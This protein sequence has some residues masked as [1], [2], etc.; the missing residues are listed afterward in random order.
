[1]LNDEP[2]RRRFERHSRLIDLGYGSTFE[3]QH[4]QRVAGY[5][6]RIWRMHDCP[7]LGT[8]GDSDQVFGLQ[9]AERLADG[10]SGY[11]ELLHQPTF[12]LQGIPLFELTPDDLL[13]DPGGNNL[14]RL[15]YMQHLA[16]LHAAT[17]SQL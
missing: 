2:H 16:A 17:G 14:R 5:Q 1:M 9:Y 11:P 15:G 12:G 6:L 10:R 7:A 3:L 8:S 13:F 4:H